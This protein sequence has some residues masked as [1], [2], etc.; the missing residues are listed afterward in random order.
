MSGS[1]NKVI[2]IGN[3]GRDP[4]IRAMQS[5]DR[6]AS[7]AIATSERWKDRQTGEQKEKTEWH[8]VSIFNQPLVSVSENYLKK[9]SKVYIEGQL[10][11]RK[12]TDQQGQERYS[13]E[14]VLRPYKGEL[15]MLDSRGGGAGDYAGGASGQM[16]GSASGSAAL[17]GAESA[18][19]TPVDSFED[20]IPF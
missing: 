1:V 9:G 16:A 13:T 6:V 12:W 11:T 3:L 5:G 2:I 4:E 10:E 7:L 14:V 8:R 19:N 18:Q 20:E 17:G 15:T